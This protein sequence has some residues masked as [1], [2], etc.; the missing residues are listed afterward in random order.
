MINF[1]VFEKLTVQ[2]YG[3]Y[4]GKSG[5][6]LC[7]IFKPGL[8][9]ILGANGLGKTTLI[10]IMF[11]L[12]TGAYD[13]SALTKSGSLGNAKLKATQLSRADKLSFSKRV[14]DRGGPV[15]SP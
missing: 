7:I 9:L 1:P 2:D 3:L 4:P 6:G 14:A 13:I 10:N 8:T 11:R 12:L 15:K 5:E